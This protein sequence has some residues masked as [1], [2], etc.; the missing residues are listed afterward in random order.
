MNDVCLAQSGGNLEQL[1]AFIGHQRSFNREW[2]RVCDCGSSARPHPFNQV[3]IHQFEELAPHQIPP[4]APEHLGL[5]IVQVQPFGITW[6]IQTVGY[7][8]FQSLDA[9]V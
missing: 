6:H 3:P 7:A 9:F 1:G 4:S 8:T 5:T 2:E